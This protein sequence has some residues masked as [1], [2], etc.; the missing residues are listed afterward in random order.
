MSMRAAFL[1]N[2]FHLLKT[3]SSDFFVDLLRD[4]F[5]EVSVIP[6]KE[7][8]GRVPG[9]HW[10]VMVLWMD[11]MDPRE[12]E[13]LGIR[14]IVIVPMYDSCSHE[15][16]FWRRY[17]QYKVLCFSR[18]LY[19]SLSAWGMDAQ[20]FQYFPPTPK[21]LAAPPSSALSAFFWP[22][23]D[24]LTWETV[25]RLVGGTRFEGIQ[26]HW[27]NAIHPDISGFPSEADVRSYGLQ[28]SSWTANRTEFE[29]LLA[30]HGVFFA[31]RA[32]EG[33]GM[34]FLE[35]MSRGMCVVA[36]DRP[37]MNEYIRHENN[38]LLYDLDNPV[39]LDFSGW[40]ELGVRAAEYCR[41]GRSRWEGSQGELQAFLRRPL[42]AYVSRP[43]PLIH[44]RRRAEAR[45]RSV[46]R[47]A[48]RVLRGR[49]E[50][51]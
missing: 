12:L 33:I 9:H 43:H 30:P 34:S 39:S 41:E 4:T 22:R 10:D 45:L 17:A 51:R 8:W 7:A 3:K 16:S 40:Q 20:Y 2:S 5:D 18:T 32:S 37:T 15:E 21:K 35:A 24:K 38:G 19:E 13:A 48:K 6:F 47:F 36:P 46:Y 42:R 23:T 1:A 50:G 28:V 14:N 26:F 29:N 49:K 27:T 11:M 31:S 25:K 44:V